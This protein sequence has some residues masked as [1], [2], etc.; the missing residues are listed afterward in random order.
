M[1]L[2]IPQLYR[3]HVFS[4]QQDRPPGHPHGS[5]VQRGS[6][7]LYEYLTARLE[8]L[9]QPD[10]G[11]TAT[12]CLGFCSAGPL[13]VIY[14]EGIWYAPRSREDIDEIVQSHLVDRKPVENLIIVPR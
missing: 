4:C 2:D 3:C 9:G 5:C 6:R 11:R 10:I 12:G 8:A 13:M 14:P 7:D 1:S